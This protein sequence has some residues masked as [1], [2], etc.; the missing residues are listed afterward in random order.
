[1]RCYC[2]AFRVSFAFLKMAAVV[3]HKRACRVTFSPSNQQRWLGEK[4]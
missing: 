4:T 2:P 3:L 1:L